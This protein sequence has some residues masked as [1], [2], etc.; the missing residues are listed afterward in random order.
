MQQKKYCRKRWWKYPTYPNPWETKNPILV[1]GENQ[2][3]SACRQ[4]ADTIF[5]AR[6]AANRVNLI[7]LGKIQFISFSPSLGTTSETMNKENKQMTLDEIA[8]HIGGWMKLAI[9]KQNVKAFMTGF[10]QAIFDLFYR[11][12]VSRKLLWEILNL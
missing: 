3:T 5:I 2:V 10:L 1:M 8:K 12:Y 11:L 6:T 9:L 7:F 4:H